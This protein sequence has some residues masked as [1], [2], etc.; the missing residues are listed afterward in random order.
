VTVSIELLTSHA[1]RDR[2]DELVELLQDAVDSGA[3]VGFLPPL[4]ESV[5]RDYWNA[6]AGDIDQGR[7]LLLGAFDGRLVGS[8]QLELATRPNALHRAEVQR[9]LVHRSFRRRGIG[10]QLMRELERLAERNGR[11]LLVLDT[12]AGDPSERLYQKLGYVRAGVIPSYARSA[13]GALDATA[14]YYRQLAGVRD[15]S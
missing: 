9:L 1:S 14:F 10:E 4:A 13:G 11:T 5:A 15:D 12:R 8:V 7:R 6:V 3:S 2:L